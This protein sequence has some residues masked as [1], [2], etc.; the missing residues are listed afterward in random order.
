MKK[1]TF[2]IIEETK[3]GFKFNFGKGFKQLFIGIVLLILSSFHWIFII[4]FLVYIFTVFYNGIKASQNYFKILT[5]K[6][7]DKNKATTEVIKPFT[8]VEVKFK[9]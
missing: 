8:E 7:I 5:S 2:S 9:K 1:N 4:L 6:H 3:E